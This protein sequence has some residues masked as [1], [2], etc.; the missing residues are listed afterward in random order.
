MR[1]V[2]RRRYAALLAA[3]LLWAAPAGAENSPRFRLCADPDNLPF[4][5]TNTTT[6]G[7]YI[8]LG[9][10]VAE[11]LGR[12]FEP[13]W[14]PT[15]YAKRMVRRTLLADQCD[16]FAGLPDDAS[17]MGPRVIFS[18][19]ILRLGYALVTAPGAMPATLAELSGKRVAVQFSTPPQDLLASRSDITA[20]TTLSP[21]EAMQALTSGRADIAFIWGP[22]AGW[23]NHTQLHDTWQ[24]TPVAGDNMAWD[25]AFGFKR[26]DA[27]L[28]D[29]VDNTL[30]RVTSTIPPLAKRYGFPDAMPLKL[31]ANETAADSNAGNVEAGHQLFNDNCAHCHGP[32]AVQ[33]E[34]RRNLR[35]LQHKHGDEMDQVFTTTVTQGRVSKG[36]PSLAGVLSDQQLHNIL[37]W[38]HSVQEP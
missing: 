19:P 14:V 7:F 12:P 33:G 30:G 25:A 26:D 29:A 16:A 9:R 31:V 5:S 17:F 10:S 27:A 34:R 6:P 23:V 32:D 20:V 4:S 28:R 38:L 3:L 8:E 21:E 18:R 11:V 24:V 37:A 2:I 1:C 13:V 22:T 15:Y 36:M 35:L